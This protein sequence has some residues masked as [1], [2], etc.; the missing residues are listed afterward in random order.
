MNLFGA[1]ITTALRRVAGIHVTGALNAL[2][3]SNSVSGNLSAV[4]TLNVGTDLGGVAN[5]AVSGAL[6]VPGSGQVNIYTSCT[7]S[8]RNRPPTDVAGDADLSARWPRSLR[9]RPAP[10]NAGR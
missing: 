7:L 8:S 4:G 10:P 9:V 2:S 6:S 5:L 1:S 3:G